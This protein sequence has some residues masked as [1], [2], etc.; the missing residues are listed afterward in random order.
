MSG[1]RLRKNSV[2]D[3]YSKNWPI[4]LEKKFLSHYC[5]KK[6][7]CD[8]HKHRKILCDKNIRPA[9]AATVFLKKYHNFLQ[10]SE[11]SSNLKFLITPEQLH[12]MQFNFTRDCNC[13]LILILKYSKKNFFGA[14]PPSYLIS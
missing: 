14:A 7:S 3:L 6:N 11:L 4:K 8:K 13:A 2:Q 9:R 12:P 5:V 1:L 10:F